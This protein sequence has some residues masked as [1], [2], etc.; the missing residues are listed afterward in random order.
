MRSIIALAIAASVAACAPGYNVYEMCEVRE[1]GAFAASF[2]PGSLDY[3]GH[4]WYYRDASTG[5]E[6]IVGVAPQE[7]APVVTTNCR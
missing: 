1:V 3:R 4:V 5:Q 7:D 2:E 6:S